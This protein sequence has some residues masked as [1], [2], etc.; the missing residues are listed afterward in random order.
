VPDRRD[1]DRIR[2]ETVEMVMARASAITCGHKDAV[3]LDRLRRDPLMK[4]AVGRC[5]ETGAPLASPIGVIFDNHFP[6]RNAHDA[7]A[8]IR[9]H[10][11]DL[12]FDGWFRLGLDRLER[13]V[14]Q[15]AKS[16]E[17]DPPLH[18]SFWPIATGDALT[19][20]RRFRGIAD[21]D[22]FSSRNDL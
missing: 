18:V 15:D 19:A 5:P 9:P 17:A 11:A 20:N 8:A 21:M 22:R 13:M 10:K 4:V 7:L 16:G 6:I 2:H 12:V 14:T 1:A 3:D